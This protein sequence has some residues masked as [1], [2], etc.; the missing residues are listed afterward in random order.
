[1]TDRQIT[2]YLSVAGASGEDIYRRVTELLKNM[3]HQVIDVS[4][5]AP[6]FLP[7][8]DA[9]QSAV[10]ELIQRSGAFVG[11]LAGDAGPAEEHADGVVIEPG[12]KPLEIEYAAAR[13]LGVPQ[14][15][16]V[17]ESVLD[18]DSW[19]ARFFREVSKEQFFRGFTYDEELL[20][21]LP[22]DLLLT[23]RQQQ[24]PA[25]RAFET[26]RADFKI[27]EQ[28]SDDEAARDEVNEL[29]SLANQLVANGNGS[30]AEGAY[31]KIIGILPSEIGAYIALRDIL[32]SQGKTTEAEEIEAEISERFPVGAAVTARLETGRTDMPPTGGVTN[33]TAPRPP[34]TDW[35]AKQA[36]ATANGDATDGEPLS[37]LRKVPRKQPTQDQAPFEHLSLHQGPRARAGRARTIG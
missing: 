4:A 37:N 7:V 1:M 2:V 27:T 36:T 10:T 13:T 15:L 9:F 32:R 30:E 5:M 19:L 31:H 12:R 14:L 25:E 3:G 23:R 35:N 33:E 34:T 11:I 6:V 17:R 20:K 28:S 21:W 26:G 8:S 22:E 24:A 18:R 16:Y 29:Y